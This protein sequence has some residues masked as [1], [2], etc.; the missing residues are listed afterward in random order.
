MAV[1]PEA[2]EEVVEMALVTE[3]EE[4]WEAS[5]SHSHRAHSISGKERSTSR[6]STIHTSL[7]FSPACAQTSVCCQAPQGSVGKLTPTQVLPIVL[8]V[9][10]FHSRAGH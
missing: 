8:G 1:M 5:Q 4:S 3:A 7:V 2:G 10:S 6:R 9:Q